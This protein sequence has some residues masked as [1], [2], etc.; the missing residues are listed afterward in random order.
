MVCCLR[1]LLMLDFDEK[2]CIIPMHVELSTTICLVVN[3][4]DHVIII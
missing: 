3:L 1:I 2:G 4:S